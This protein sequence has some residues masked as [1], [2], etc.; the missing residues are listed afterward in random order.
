MPGAT[1]SATAPQPARFAFLFPGQGSQ[2]IGMLADDKLL[3]LPAVA[4]MCE[5]AREVLGYDLREICVN[6]PKEKLDDTVYAQPALL[7][8]NLAALEKLKD[9]DPDVVNACDAC[10]GL[11][12]GE[13]A[14]LV[15]AGVLSYE[16]AFKVVK[17][18]AEAMAAAAREGSHGMLSVVGL[19]DDA[20]KTIVEESKNE[21]IASSPDC[22]LEITNF[23][24]P[25]GRVLSGDKVAL[26][27]AQRRAQ[28]AGAIK[29]A[30]LAV[31]GA[32]HT[33]RMESAKE[34]L[35][36]ALSE[37]TFNAPRANVAIYSNVTGLPM[38]AKDADGVRASLATQ[39]VSPVMWEQTL[40]NLIGDGKTKF[41]ELGPN[42][43]IKSMT[44]RVSLD[45]WREMKGVQA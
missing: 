21:V 18:R 37:V 20:L 17:A 6:G 12:L 14:A 15:F 10:A 27:V 43:Q 36:K 11:S 39:L 31:S 29:V 13:Y 24:F 9:Q 35:E 19:D 7:L 33:K 23:L 22:V 25:Q 2:A 40:K 3:E 38:T 44:K 8:A 4:K 45:V 41:F 42:S 30:F 5:V 32:F 16:D 1:D 34:A 28:A 26:D